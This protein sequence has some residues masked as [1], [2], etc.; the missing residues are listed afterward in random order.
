LQRAGVILDY[1]SPR[2]AI[3][4]LADAEYTGRNNQNNLPA[5]TQFDGAVN[6]LFAKGSLTAAVSNIFN[7]QA[8]V[9]S[10]VYNAIPYYTIGGYVVPTVARPLTPRSYSVTYSVKFGPGALGNTHIAQALPQPRTG[11]RGAGG[12]RAASP[13]PS[14]PPANPLDVSSND[15][16]CPADAHAT[17]EE[18]STALK[19]YV[20]QIEAAKTAQG[21]PAT[22]PAPDIPD[23]T[24]TYHGLGSSYALTIQPHFQNN[25]N[26][27]TLASQELTAA[28]PSPQPNGQPAQ[29]G[30]RGSEFRVFF[31]C[32]TLHIAHPEDVTA[33]NLYAPTSTAFGA[34]QI[35]FMPAYGLYA[36]QRQP[37]QEGQQSFR[38]YTLPSTPPKDP[39]EVRTAVEC[40]SDMHNT[41][42]EALGELRAYFTSGTAPKLWTITAH[43]A[44]NGTWYALVPGD[45]LIIMS[46]LF[47]GHV[48]AAT[49][50]DVVPKGWDGVM[51]P[52]LNYNTAWGL[53]LI[54]RANPNGPGGP[55]PG[56]PPPGGPPG[57][58]PP[59]PPQSGR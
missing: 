20:A 25:A 5:Y 37:Q 6:V 32:L 1:K 57:G 10:S 4:Y 48:S 30:G 38:V 3:E 49:P 9:F 36:V 44:K 18:I 46:L 24:V 12:F 16:T 15:Q 47:C 7:T 19:A 51:Q 27:V 31:G 11:G 33:H 23:A 54:R 14:S 13:L 50:Q 53:Y 21:Y 55:G 40:T 59:P 45:P 34:P 42:S 39:F 52:D 28:T 26:T 17:A 29:R 35:T 56:G 22:M 8:G 43:T 2:S 58:A 41:A